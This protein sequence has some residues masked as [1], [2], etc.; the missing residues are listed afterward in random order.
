MSATLYFSKVNVVSHIYDIYDKPKELR[1]ILKKL[2]INI[3]NDVKYE[4]QDVRVDE[5]GEVHEYNAVFKFRS[6]DKLDDK[7]NNAIVG[8][9]VK[10]SLLF[11]NDIDEKT[12]VVKKIPVENSEIIQFYFDVYREV[13]VFYTTNRFGRKEFNDAFKE[14]LTASMNKEEKGYNFEISL[15]KPNLDIA[16]IKNELRKIGELESLKIH[17]IPPNPDD[18]LL[19]EISNNGE[20]IL[21]SMKEGNVTNKS[22][23]FTSKS[24]RGLNLNAKIINEEIGKIN[25]IHSKLSGKKALGLGYASVEATSV[26]GKTFT[27]EDTKPIKQKISEEEKT[28]GL[29]IDVCKNKV[30][31]I[32][33]ML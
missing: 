17:I 11:I 16:D 31:S 26:D 28:R 13:V 30:L 22:I 5:K 14:L 24:L 33:R 29:F 21:E 25:K 6:I 4:K 1:K 12:N 18:E 2:L 19:D 8:N 27:T 7:Y 20:E 23:V 15:I 10:K 32:I 3:N 9:V